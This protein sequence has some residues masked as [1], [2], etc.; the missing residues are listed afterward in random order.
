MLFAWAEEVMDEACDF[1]L[2]ALRDIP[3]QRSNYVAFEVKQTFHKTQS[4][5]P[6]L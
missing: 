3:P 6:N 1:P 2:L 4:A 5:G